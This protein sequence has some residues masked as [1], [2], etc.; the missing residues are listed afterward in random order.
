MTDALSEYRAGMDGVHH[1]TDQME[2]LW[3]NARDR[4][5]ERLLVPSAEADA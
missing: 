1:L 3:S 5:P 2:E 4:R